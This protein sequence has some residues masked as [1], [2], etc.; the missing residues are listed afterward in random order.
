[1]T[2][3]REMIVTDVSQLL[4][5]TDGRALGAGDALARSAALNCHAPVVAD[6]SA[7][8]CRR[9]AASGCSTSPGSRVD[10]VAQ[11]QVPSH[12]VV[13]AV[14]DRSGLIFAAKTTASGLIAL[15]VAFTFNLDQPYWALLTV[16]SSRSHSRAGTSWRRASTA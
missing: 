10:H 1:M 8:V 5:E 11:K 13:R 6:Q 2:L 4:G 16:S 12:R 7:A 14:E 9:P 3:A 15:L